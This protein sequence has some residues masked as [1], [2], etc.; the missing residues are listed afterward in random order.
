M[1]RIGAAAM[2]SE[3]WG[4]E[5]QICWELREDQWKTCTCRSGCRNSNLIPTLAHEFSKWQ[6]QRWVRTGSAKV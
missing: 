4:A 5:I 2:H 1:A 6:C 3:E